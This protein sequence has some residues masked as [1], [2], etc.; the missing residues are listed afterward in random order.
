MI[1]DLL[2]VFGCVEDAVEVHSLPADV[3]SKLEQIVAD[4]A[5][6]CG[7]D[8]EDETTARPGIAR[9]IEVAGLG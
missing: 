8:A 6:I 5:V 3:P 9:E 7:D 1:S 2:R 4:S